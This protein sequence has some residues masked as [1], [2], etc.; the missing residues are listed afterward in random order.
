MAYHCQQKANARKVI[1]NAKPDASGFIPLP[2]P[3]SG[4]PSTVIIWGPLNCPSDAGKKSS[5]LAEAMQKAGVPCTHTAQVSF[6]N[7][8]SDQLV[9]VDKIFKWEPPI[10]F[11]NMRVKSNPQVNEIIAEYR[12]VSKSATNNVPQKSKIY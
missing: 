10:V 4:D 8:T 11:I 5:A 6:P 7:M 2:P 9:I 1:A 3:N 12:Q